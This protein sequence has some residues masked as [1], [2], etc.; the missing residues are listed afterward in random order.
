MAEERS[1]VLLTC[2]ILEMLCDLKGFSVYT[3][4]YCGIGVCCDQTD[5]FWPSG[6]SEQSK[7]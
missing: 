1:C 7:K 5:R 4:L 2:D 3:G 6:H